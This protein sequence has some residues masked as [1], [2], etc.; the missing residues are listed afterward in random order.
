MSNPGGKTWQ[1]A[2]TRVKRLAEIE[3]KEQTLI[4]SNT[5]ALHVPPLCFFDVLSYTILPQSLMEH[6]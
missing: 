6:N 5:H 1:F 2:A 3:I 4:E